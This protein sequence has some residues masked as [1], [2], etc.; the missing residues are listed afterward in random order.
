[1]KTLYT[2]F[3][4]SDMLALIKMSYLFIA[5]IDSGHHFWLLLLLLAGMAGSIALLIFLLSAYIN[6]PSTHKHQ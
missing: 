6:L 3:F 1:M 5:N 4:F 2:I